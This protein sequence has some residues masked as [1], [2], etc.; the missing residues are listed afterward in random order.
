LLK[1]RACPTLSEGG[2]HVKNSCRVAIV[3]ATA[4]LFALLLAPAPGLGQAPAPAK[5]GDQPDDKAKAARAK[6]IAE[7]FERNARVLTV[8]DRQ[9]KVV[10][11]VGERALYWDPVF[12]PDRTRLAVTKRD[13]ESETWDLWV[14][15]VATGKSTRIT[16]SPKREPARAPVWSPDGSQVA[17][18][19]LRGGYEGLYRKASNGEGTEE[20]LYQHP[21][22]GMT[23]RDWSLDGRF[24]S[25]STSDLSGGTLYALPLAGVGERKPIEVF[26]SES[27]LQ[28]SR[29]SPDSRFLS[30]GSNQSGKIEVYVRPFDPSAGVG[31]TPAAGPWQVSDQG[32]QGPAFWRRDGKELYYLA[33]DQ[34]VMAVEV[35]TAPRLE[36]GKPKLLFRL[37]EAIPVTPALAS[38]SR[39]GERVVIAV[40][41]AP[42]LQ[43]ITVFDR[44]GNV[45]SKVGE[46]GRYV[47]LAFS[48]DGTR[49]AVMRADP[50]TGNGDIWTFDVASGRG[51]PVTNDTFPDNAPIWS[52]DGS[53]VAYVSTRKNFA[54]I[55]RKAWDGTGNEEQVFQ[56]TPGAGM[57]LT[58]WSAD[59]KFLTFGGQVLHVVPLGGDQK[60]L[61]RKAIEW[62]RDE[63]NV[64]QARF[65]PDSR[66]MA[67]LSDELNGIFFEVYVRPFEASKAD[68]SA[69]GAKGV[70]VST[71]GARG[72]IFWRQDGKEMY[73]LTPEWEVMAVDV[74][75]TPTFQAGTPRLL[76]KLPGPLVGNPLQWK[77]VSRDGQRFV[78]TTNVPV[79]VSA[80]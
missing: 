39:D 77:N 71:A 60:A 42:T 32:G 8:F 7:Q 56:H 62:L 29:L 12:S 69:G 13:L 30:Y 34:G 26:R 53:Q 57:M 25:F 66:F 80:R 46:P 1:K 37:S 52:P 40:P 55:Y 47:E 17:Y 74:T 18:G 6:Q 19:A 63:Y 5:A 54:S 59:G 2:F 24:L 21:G 49:V 78:F 75:T 23:L 43:Q 73:Y 9:G 10:T 35:S 38:V 15:D 65:S 22:S 4:A 33:A 72:M 31:A 28:G 3:I 51:T 16:S 70:R 58:D 76:F 11:T 61:E 48:P 36:F 68:V 67:Y 27:Q 20:L 79:S 45:L 14:L 50:R 44:Q 64:A 41:H